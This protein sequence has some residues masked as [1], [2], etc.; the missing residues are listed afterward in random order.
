MGRNTS[1]KMQFGGKYPCTANDQH[2]MF[3]L[4]SANSLYR[5]IYGNGSQRNTKTRPYN[6]HQAAT[7]LAKAQVHIQMLWF[8]TL[9]KKN[10]KTQK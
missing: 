2:N 3:T 5:R 4:L 10:K 8:S 9:E 7:S 6:S 1:F